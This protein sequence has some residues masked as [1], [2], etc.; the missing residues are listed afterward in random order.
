MDSY[1]GNALGL[2]DMHGN[3]KQ[4]CQDFFDKDY[5]RVS[6]PKDPTGPQSGDTRVNRGGWWCGISSCCRAAS[7]GV[8]QPPFDNSNATGFR[9]AMTIPARAP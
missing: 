4:W 6:Y 7:R 5:Y 3:V 1:K 8:G 2:F 9:L